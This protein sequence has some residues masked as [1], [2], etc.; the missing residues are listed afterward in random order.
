LRSGLFTL[1]ELGCKVQSSEAQHQIPFL[2]STATP[3][4]GAIKT[5]GQKQA[6]V[7]CYKPM[8]NSRSSS[9]PELFGAIGSDRA[10]AERKESSNVA[11]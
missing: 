10:K 6:L 1:L 4:T 5:I 11:V 8:K 2:I 7:T 3:R 9:S